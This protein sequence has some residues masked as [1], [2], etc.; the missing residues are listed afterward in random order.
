[1]EV[2]YAEDA[3]LVEERDVPKRDDEDVVFVLALD[4]RKEFL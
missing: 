4:T 2:E 1:L 3:I